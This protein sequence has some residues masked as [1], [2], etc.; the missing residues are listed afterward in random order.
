GQAAEA[1]ARLEGPYASATVVGL[2]RVGR[3]RVVQLR[4]E[5]AGAALV[6]ERW[7]DGDEGWRVVAADVVRV[8][9]PA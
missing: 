8:E 2:A 4:L 7:A 5:G 1:Y 6:Q 9:R 3:Q